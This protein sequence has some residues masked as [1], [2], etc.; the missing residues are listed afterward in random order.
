VCYYIS[1]IARFYD[2]L[3]TPATSSGDHL[4]LLDG[5]SHNFL[6]DENGAL[7]AIDP[8]LVFVNTQPARMFPRASFNYAPE[9]QKCD[10]VFIEAFE[11]EKGHNDLLWGAKPPSELLAEFGPELTWAVD[12]W[13]LGIVVHAAV[14]HSSPYPDPD[15][16]SWDVLKRRK[17]IIRYFYEPVSVIGASLPV[18]NF[19]VTTDNFRQSDPLTIA[20]HLMGSGRVRRGTLSA[21][22]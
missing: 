20:D 10:Q 18:N 13:A 4:V 1:F 21:E 3:H 5:F 7:L 19:Q 14:Y 8:G 15:Y 22:P 17:E 9:V 16:N 2:R 6:L 11:E 12:V